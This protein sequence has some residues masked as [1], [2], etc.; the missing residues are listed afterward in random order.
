MVEGGGSGARGP[1]EQVC[2]S[3]IT[4]DLSQSRQ[5]QIESCS[6]QGFSYTGRVKI[7]KVG[8]KYVEL[9]RISV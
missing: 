9:R 8:K 7:D 3:I 1:G 4:I 2:P 6:E 5:R